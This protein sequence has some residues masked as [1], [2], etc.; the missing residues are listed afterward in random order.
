MK[1]YIEEFIEA[2]KNGHAYDY[3]TNNYYKMSKSELAD[4]LKEYIWAFENVE[5]LNDGL[6]DL[7]IYE[8]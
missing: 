5:C 6:E 7:I 4:I 3:I 8:D 1:D 2:M